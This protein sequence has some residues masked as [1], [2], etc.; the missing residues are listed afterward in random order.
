MSKTNTQNHGGDK[1]KGR[2]GRKQNEKELLFEHQEEII[3]VKVQKNIYENMHYLSTTSEIS[4]N[5]NSASRKTAAKK[6]TV[7]CYDR[8]PKKSSLQLDQREPVRRFLQHN[9]VFVNF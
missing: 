3:S 1:K 5:R 4:L 9:A 7:L 6:S 2:K 8:N